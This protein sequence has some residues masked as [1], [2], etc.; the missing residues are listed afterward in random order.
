MAGRGGAKRLVNRPNAG[1][2]VADL[3]AL[4]QEQVEAEAI[5]LDEDAADV[6]PARPPEG[7]VSTA[8]D[9]GSATI[10]E[11]DVLDN[12]VGGDV[13]ADDL[14]EAADAYED[15]PALRPFENLPHLPADLREAFD[16]FK[17]AIVH[18]RVAGWQ[19]VSLEDVLATLDALRQFA[20]APADG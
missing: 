14:A 12:G 7:M 3:G 9:D 11:D 15:E 1:P 8:H 18:H 2:A 17:L 16:S 6:P 4:V 20:L 19:E 13:I 10:V 5:E